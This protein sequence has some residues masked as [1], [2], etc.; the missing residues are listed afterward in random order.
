MYSIESYILRYVDYSYIT[1]GEFCLANHRGSFK[2]ND[3]PIE[4]IA[5]LNDRVQS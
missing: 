5:E 2:M 3:L 4:T 1:N